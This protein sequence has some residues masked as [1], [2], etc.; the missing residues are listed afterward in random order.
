MTNYSSLELNLM[1]L[2][3]L[4][5]EMRT[6]YEEY[7]DTSQPKDEF[8]LRAIV[9]YFLGVRLHDFIEI[10]NLICKDFVDR[11]NIQ[12]DTCL[13]SLCGPIV[14]HRRAIDELRKLYLAHM[15]QKQSFSA[16]KLPSLWRAGVFIH[17]F[18]WWTRTSRLM[19]STFRSR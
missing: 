1:R 10:R 6:I 2:G 12:L 16:R 17:F 7:P 18:F 14:K 15:Q 11:G 5:T 8:H 4:R 9:R 19:L 13:K 3:W